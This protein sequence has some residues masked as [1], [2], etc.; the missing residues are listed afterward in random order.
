M[1]LG[2]DKY[3]LSLW[4]ILNAN[5]VQTTLVWV[6][7]NTSHII[8]SDLD[9]TLP[10]FGTYI[11]PTHHVIYLFYTYT[12]YVNVVDRVS[13]TGLGFEQMLFKSNKGGYWR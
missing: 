5:F 8:L 13:V 10:N 3:V 12:P 7:V 11:R 9:F 2:S 4:W 6:S 1:G